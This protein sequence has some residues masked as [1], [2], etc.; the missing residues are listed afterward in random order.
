MR[1]RS[2]A[3]A[4]LL[5]LSAAQVRAETSGLTQTGFTVTFTR[6]VGATPEKLWDA[7]L[8]IGNWWSSSHTWSGKA[9]NMSLEPRAN[10]CW[11]ES[12]DGASVQHG[13][14]V[15]IQPN[16]VLRFYAGLGP[17]QDRAATGVLTFALA[18][19]KENK[20]KTTLKLTYRVA[21]PADAGLQEVAPAV[22]K[23]MG[24]QVKR[25][26][27]YVETGKPE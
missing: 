3:I 25:L 17:L 1:G 19:S 15:W 5:L 9:S 24:E 4:L 7:L 14:V 18:A 13:N 20:D 11:C 16:R 8:Q 10:G 23:V 22:D 26:A 12:W 2:L 6:E 21:G 27:A